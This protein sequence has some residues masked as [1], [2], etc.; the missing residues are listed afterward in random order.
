[1]LKKIVSEGV[2]V[3]FPGLQLLSTATSI[4]PEIKHVENTIMDFFLD[5][6]IRSFG[7]Q[8]VNRLL[9]PPV[10]IS[11]L[12]MSG[13]ITYYSSSKVGKSIISKFSIFLFIIIFMIMCVGYMLLIRVGSISN[14][15]I[16]NE[17]VLKSYDF[18]DFF[19]PLMPLVGVGQQLIGN[20]LNK[21]KARKQKRRER[22]RRLALLRAKQNKFNENENGE[23]EVEDEAL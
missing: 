5:R 4:A 21:R 14:K 15:D 18:K 6:L 19:L 11:I 20:F 12:L 17:L 1:M 23:D 16:D 8:S 3:A 9:Q 7:L 10:M 2:K 22:K 13:I